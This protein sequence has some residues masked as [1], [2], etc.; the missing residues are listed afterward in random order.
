MEL[1][2]KDPL[3]DP[4]NVE[5]DQLRKEN[6]SLRSQLKRYEPTSRYNGRSIEDWFRDAERWRDRYM[7]S[8]RVLRQ[9][10]ELTGKPKVDI[11][12]WA[13]IGV[14][15]SMALRDTETSQEI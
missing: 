3:R 12:M 15:A 13:T 14:L 11:K 5:L 6:D 8:A 7:I 9:I 4:M 10:E 1:P 2:V